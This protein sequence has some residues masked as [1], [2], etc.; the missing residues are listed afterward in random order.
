VLAKQKDPPKAVSQPSRF[1]PLMTP[2]RAIMVGPLRSTTKEHRF[3]R[4]LPF[5]EMLWPSGAR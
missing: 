4:G 3:N 1:I 5:I 2:M